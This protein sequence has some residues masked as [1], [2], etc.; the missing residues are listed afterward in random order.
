MHSCVSKIDLTQ[1][2]PLIYVRCPRIPADLE[3]KISYRR[4]NHNPHKKVKVFG[5][6]ATIT[7]NI[8]VEIGL[9]L[10][11]GCITTSADKLDG[12]YLIPEREKLM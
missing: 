7:T 10:P 9:E 11:A 8:Q 5:Y 4:S 6:Q 1:D 12:S 2:E 3:A